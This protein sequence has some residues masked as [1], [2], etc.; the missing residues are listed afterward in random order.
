[1]TLSPSSLRMLFALTLITLSTSGC[2]LF[3]PPEVSDNDL[4]QGTSPELDQGSMSMVDQSKESDAGE[5]LGEDTIDAG[6]DLEPELDQGQDQNP[7]TEDMDM[8]PSPPQGWH[9]PRHGH[10]LQLTPKQD[11]TLPNEAMIALVKLRNERIDFDLLAEEGADIVFFSDDGTRLSHEIEY[12][13]KAPN[14][15]D[16]WVGYP[17]SSGATRAPI[18]MYY[19]TPSP[20]DAQDPDALWRDHLT[21][22]HFTK[23]DATTQLPE[24][25]S[26]NG[27]HP[28]EQSMGLAFTENAIAG[29]APRF[30]ADV[31][32]FIGFDKELGLG[33]EPGSQR[34]YELWFK[35]PT[36]ALVDAQQMSI[37]ADDAACRGFSVFYGDGGGQTTT[38]LGR[39]VFANDDSGCGM[40]T[41]E[42]SFVTHRD[43]T[44]E[45]WHHLA[46]VL[47]RPNN[48]FEVWIDG[49]RDLPESIETNIPTS[50]FTRGG[51][52]M[53]GDSTIPSA[54][55]FIGTIDE[56]RVWDGAHTDAWFAVQ[57]EIGRDLFFTYGQPE[58]WR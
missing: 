57:D 15:A 46:L 25:A 29:L 23:F 20:E 30:R 51:D 44:A 54:R 8:S 33:A 24:D 50:A 58:G 16:I 26:R 1:M 2:F 45:T 27:A 37:L 36:A 39:L 43:T 32:D 6:A 4:D 55:S 5:D 12:F 38:V 7:A 56:F 13:S 9:S 31:V 14:V 21:V 52:L 34:V 42:S 11:L 47:D 35:I 17:A 10:R 22:H 49:T 18:W 40:T 53:L 28:S 41:P 19:D 48:T 3:D